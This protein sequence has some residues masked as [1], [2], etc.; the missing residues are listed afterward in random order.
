MLTAP[1]TVRIAVAP[2]RD[3]GMM[4][5]QTKMVYDQLLGAQY[6]KL[7]DAVVQRKA[8]FDREA[9]KIEKSAGREK[10][11]EYGIKAQEVLNKLQADTA[12]ELRAL[13]EDYQSKLNKLHTQLEDKWRKEHGYVK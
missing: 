3:Y 7:L 2:D 12:E 1:P 13:Q 4:M 6:G 11:L 8:G 5:Q 10:A 9:A